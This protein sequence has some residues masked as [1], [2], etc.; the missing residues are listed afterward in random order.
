MP[1]GAAETLSSREN[2]TGFLSDNEVTCTDV[3]VFV[4]ESEPNTCTLPF[5]GVMYI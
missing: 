3:F 4:S 5:G 1:V 2:D